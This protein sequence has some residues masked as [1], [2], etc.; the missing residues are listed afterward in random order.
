IRNANIVIKNAPEGDAI[1]PEDVD[2]YVSE[3]RFL[4]AL[5]YFH[6]VRN[7]GDIPLRTEENMENVELAKSSKEEVYDFILADLLEAETNLPEEQELLGRPTKFAAKTLLAD[8][9]LQL[10]QYSEA[11][12][13]ARSEEHTSELQSRENLVCRL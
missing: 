7:W 9:Y 5:S 11:R 1:S 10:G 12:E 6:L 2:K 8:V 4:R 13:K 3:A